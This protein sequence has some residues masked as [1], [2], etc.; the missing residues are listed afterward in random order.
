MNT[1]GMLVLAGALALVAPM[2]VSATAV[3]PEKAELTADLH[4]LASFANRQNALM[5]G[6][7]TAEVACGKACGRCEQSISCEEG[8]SPTCN[9]SDTGDKCGWGPWER[10]VYTC[11]CTCTATPKP[12]PPPGPPGGICVGNP[13]PVVCVTLPP[14][15][16]GTTGHSNEP[17]GVLTE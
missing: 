1:Q 10:A 11:T 12:P 3:D 15:V 8:Y 17:E 5:L 6:D 16:A 13:D 14:G 9:C 2:T 7:A 4:D